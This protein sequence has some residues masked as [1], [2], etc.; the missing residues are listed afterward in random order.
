MFLTRR[1]CSCVPINSH[2]LVTVQ[3]A[4]RRERK[5]KRGEKRDKL[6]PPAAAELC[7][8]GLLVSECLPAE[9][10]S[11]GMEKGLGVARA[12]GEASVRGIISILGKSPKMLQPGRLDCG[13][14]KHHFSRQIFNL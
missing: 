9:M 13:R 11:V 2:L 1:H 10:D 14:G 7:K 4:W 8:A 3:E 5:G 12:A 6:N